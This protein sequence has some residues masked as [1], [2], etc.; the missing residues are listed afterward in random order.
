MRNDYPRGPRQ[1]VLPSLYENEQKPQDFEGQTYTRANDHSRL[2]RQLYAIYQIMRD[3]HWHTLFDLDRETHHQYA[4][5]S[6]SARLRDLRKPKWGGYT[7][8]RRRVQSAGTW[9]YQI[10]HAS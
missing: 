8:L 6:I 9:E 1:K 7:V 5:T 4:L 3:H 10:P 2:T